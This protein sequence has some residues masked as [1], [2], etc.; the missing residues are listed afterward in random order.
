[1]L[2][3]LLRCTCIYMYLLVYAACVGTRQ[4]A[5]YLPI[6]VLVCAASRIVVEWQFTYLHVHVHVHVCT[7]CTNVNCAASRIRGRVAGVPFEKFHK[8]SS[9]II[10]AG[11]FG[12]DG[13]G[14]IKNRL[15]FG[16]N[17]LVS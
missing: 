7:T 3:N 8:H 12:W 14:K 17:N 11:V 2:A 13:A 15:A 1:M 5:I 4:V 10:R 6:T 16:A 9:E